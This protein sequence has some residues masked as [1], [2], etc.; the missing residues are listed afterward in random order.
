MWGAEPE[1]T[2][3]RPAVRTGEVAVF[4]A[5]EVGHFWAHRDSREWELAKEEGKK[6]VFGEWTGGYK[7]GGVST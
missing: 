4:V 1:G 3:R 7:M 2:V 6:E 5:S